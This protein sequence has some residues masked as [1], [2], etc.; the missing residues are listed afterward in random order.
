M[1]LSKSLHSLCR[2]GILKMTF[3]QD[4]SVLIKSSSNGRSR[5]NHPKHIFLEDT[6]LDLRSCDVTELIIIP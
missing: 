6:I 2:F 1:G 4:F 5:D 3:S